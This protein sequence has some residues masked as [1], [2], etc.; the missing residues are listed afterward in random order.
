MYDKGSNMDDLKKAV[1]DVNKA[2]ERRPIDKFYL[3]N[4]DFI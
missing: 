3:V 1:D 4:I 2:L